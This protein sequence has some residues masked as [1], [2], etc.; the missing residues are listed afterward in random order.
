MKIE[1]YCNPY[2]ALIAYTAV[3]ILWLLAIKQ[4]RAKETDSWLRLFI[5]SPITAPIC[6]PMLLF[7]MFGKFTKHHPQQN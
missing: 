3:G 4:G 2:Y 5:F 7:W 1:T 6:V